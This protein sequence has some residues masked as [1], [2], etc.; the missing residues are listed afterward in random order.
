MLQIVPK[1]LKNRLY[2]KSVI[3]LMNLR[4]LQSVIDLKNLLFR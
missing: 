2:L 4:F 1:F 3:D